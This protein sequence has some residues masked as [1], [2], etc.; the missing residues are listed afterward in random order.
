MVKLQERDVRGRK[1]YMVTVPA[2][3]VRA[4]GWRKGDYLLITLDGDTITIKKLEVDE[5]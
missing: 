3:Y 1:H 5:R 4:L 2:E